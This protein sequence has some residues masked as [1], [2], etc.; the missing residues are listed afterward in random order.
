ML[1]MQTQNTIEQ[2]RSALDF[3]P[4]SGIGGAVKVFIVSK[5]EVTEAEK[6]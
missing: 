1:S 6:N 5:N 3:E 4:G 2:V